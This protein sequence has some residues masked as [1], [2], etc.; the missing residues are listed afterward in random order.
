MSNDNSC[1]HCGAKMVSYTFTLNKGLA[2][3][4]WKLAK[5]SETHFVEIRTLRLTT[6]EWTN[7]QKLRYW[8]LIEKKMEDETGKGGFWKISETGLLFLKSR[9][10]LPKKVTMYRNTVQSYSEEKVTFSQVTDGYEYR[11]DYVQQIIDQ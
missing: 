3:C 6:S 7:F 5:A 10:P 11:S 2:R 1:H 8:N 9:R 4:L